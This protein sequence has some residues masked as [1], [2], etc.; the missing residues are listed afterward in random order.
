MDKNEIEMLK[1]RAKTEFERTGL[2]ANVLERMS[3]KEREKL[4][5]EAGLNP[6]EYDF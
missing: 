4:L 3:L 1:E 2:D 5:E 6:K